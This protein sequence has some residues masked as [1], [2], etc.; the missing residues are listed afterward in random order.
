MTALDRVEGALAAAGCG[1]I[2]NGMTRCPAHDD[3][4][5]SLSITYSDAKV[6]LHCMAGCD[7]QA[8]LAALGLETAD[9]FDDETTTKSTI[10]S[11]Y[12][13]HDE[14]GALAFQVCRMAPK[15]FRQRRPDGAGGWIW[16]MKGVRRVPYRL[17]ELVAAGAAGRH[18]FIVEGEKD[19][20]TLR[21]RGFVATCNPGGAGKW[22]DD[23]NRHLAGAKVVVLPDNDK[24]GRDHARAVATSVSASRTVVVV[25]ELPGLG[26]HEDVSDWLTAGHTAEELKDLVR[27]A[28]LFRTESHDATRSEVMSTFVDTAELLTAV[29]AALEKY[30]IFASAYQAVAVALWVLHTYI[31]ESFDVTPYLHVSSATKQAGKTRLFD[32]LFRLVA[33]PWMTGGVSAA[34]L[35]RKIERIMPT[36]LLDEVDTLFGDDPEMTSSIRGILNTGYSRSGVFTRCVGQGQNI[37]EKDFATY[38]AKAFAGIGS[39]KLPDTVR[40]RSIPIVL[41]RR[42][43]TERTPDRFIQR[44]ADAELAPL[45]AQLRDWGRAHVDEIGSREHQPLDGLSDRQEDIWQPLFAIAALAGGDWPNLAVSAALRLHESAEDGD[46]TM[47]LLSHVRDAFDDLGDR[48]ST[49]QLL[50]HLTDRGDAS[51]WVKFWAEDL[52]RGG[53]HLKTAGRGLARYLTPLGIKPEKIRFGDKTRQ[54]YER[55]DFEDAWMRYLPRSVISQDFDGTTEHRRSELVFESNGSEPKSAP[56]QGCSVVPSKDPGI[57][58]QGDFDGTQPSGIR[59]CDQCGRGVVGPNDDGRWV[60]PHCDLNAVVR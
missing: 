10:I 23:Y 52:E 41:R 17:P 44:Q 21:G 57:T 38:S 13:Y 56:E 15:S 35:F 30:V 39:D 32:V 34:A 46:L 16:N 45:A 6:L 14:S 8:V 53:A 58:E 33:K 2:R 54:G 29:Q 12:D 9:L 5:P 55:S 22:K 42:S 47:L 7:L 11:T 51:P 36:L 49:V 27:A 3:S 4:T 50:E 60:H 1:E 20:E 19:V 25:V 31:V 40:D 24:P 26:E 37:E 48:L 43:P 28:P 59:A 18:V